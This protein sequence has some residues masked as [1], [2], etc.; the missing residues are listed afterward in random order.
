MIVKAIRNGVKPERLSAAL[1]MPMVSHMLA[2]DD[3]ADAQRVYQAE[4][5]WFVVYG[6]ILYAV[7][8]TV[9]NG[10]FSVVFGQGFSDV[11]GLARVVGAGALFNLATANCGE[12]LLASGRSRVIAVIRVMSILAAAA[13]AIWLIPAHVAARIRS[14]NLLVCR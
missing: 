7:L 3:F 14:S 6:A 2:R 1:F 9:P 4:A 5:R 11:P 12:F 13:L 8:L 10:A